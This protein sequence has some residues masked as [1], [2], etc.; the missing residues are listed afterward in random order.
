MS[1]RQGRTGTISPIGTRERD[2]VGA[3]QGRP[4]P[5][6]VRKRRDNRLVVDGCGAVVAADGAAPYRLDVIASSVP[7]VIASVGGWLFDQ[8]MA[9]WRVNI[10]T[11]GDCDVRPLQILGIGASSLSDPLIVGESL[12]TQVLAVSSEVF[13]RIPRVRQNLVT[14]LDHGLL[15]IV[16]WGGTPVAKGA[17]HVESVR[18]RLS[19]AARAFKA[20]SLVAASIPHDSVTGTESYVVV[21]KRPTSGHCG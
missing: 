9:G 19:A 4:R 5:S 14:A 3:V 1:G 12:R 7:D 17:Y 20:Q 8:G 2:Q 11:E 16:V 13:V 21:R 15:E 18:H 6:N 10:H